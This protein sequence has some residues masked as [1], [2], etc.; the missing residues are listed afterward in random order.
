MIK[1]GIMMSQNR[2]SNVYTT[3]TAEK[4]QQSGRRHATA[5]APHRQQRKMNIEQFNRNIVTMRDDLMATAVRLS[6]NSET[7][8][9]LVQEVMLKMWS[10]RRELDRHT[11]PKALAITILRNRFYDGRRHARHEMIVTDMHPDTGREDT[12]VETA[13]EM[14]V[15]RRIIDSLP[16]LQAQILRMKEIEG[17][18]K[19]EIIKITGCTPESLRQNLSRARRRIK[20][21]FM[22]ISAYNGMRRR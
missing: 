22:R 6:G 7:A 13:D 21:E 17:Y 14:D 11:C 10:M 19:E 1:N 2:I 4:P 16:P 3:R 20:E 12:T 5:R 8:E 9:D 15:I 18:D